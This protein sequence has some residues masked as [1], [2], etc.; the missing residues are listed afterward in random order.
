MK[1]DK[2]QLKD[3]ILTKARKVVLESEVNAPQP[4]PVQ[5]KPTVSAAAPAI[6]A[7]VNPEPK[8]RKKFIIRFDKA[9]TP[10]SVEFSER[11]FLIG[12]TRLSFENIEDALNKKYNIVLDNGNGMV[13]DA[14]KIQK[15]LK[16][17]DFS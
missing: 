2:N 6:P 17:K 9:T 8:K 12:E 3:Y 7:P 1:M 15:I 16:Y 11:G 10:W 13:L 4:L 14:V 5:S